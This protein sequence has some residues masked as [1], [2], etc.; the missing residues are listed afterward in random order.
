MG[1]VDG[2]ADEG[3]PGDVM[4]A[5]W[6]VHG[7]HSIIALTAS[8]HQDV[9]AVTVD[10]FNFSETYQTPV[11]LLFDE[12]VGHMRESWR[13]QELGRFHWWTVCGCRCRR[14][15]ITIRDPRPGGKGGE[16]PDAFTGTR[17]SIEHGESRPRKLPTV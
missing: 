10:A 17:R 16:T 15:W 13:C 5:R 7:D 11:V 12:V 2:P 3:E 1:A 8:N 6:G 4:Q 14:A 9:F